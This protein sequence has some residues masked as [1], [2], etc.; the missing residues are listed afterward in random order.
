M[1]ITLLGT[2]SAE[3]WPGLFCKCKVCRT[4]RKLRGKN[5]RSR[6]SALLDGVVKIDLPP[7]TFHHVATQNL[8]LTAL[9]FLVFT[10]SHDDHLAASEL[11]YL[12]WMFVPEP[13]TPPLKVLGSSSVLN[14]IR[15][16][17]EG[18]DLPLELICLEALEP[19]VVGKWT[20]TPV[21]ANHDPDTV[22]Y[23][24]ILSNSE[25]TLLYATDTGWYAEPTWKHLEGLKLDGIVVEA[26]RGPTEEG[27][28]GHLS[29]GDV[30]RM[31]ERLL[32]SRTIQKSTPVTVTHLS[33]LGGLLHEQIEA[34][35]CPHRIQVGYDGMTLHI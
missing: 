8:D 32:A 18:R 1:E 25:K 19:T 12:S 21:L 2:G 4:S 34:I 33:H 7:D 9:D 31:R 11:Q 22:C 23:N 15:Q 6:T 14:K 20:V 5:I 27:Y 30:V 16:Y 13:F 17:N 28:T 29:F 35:L 26:S 3:G 10:H 24:L